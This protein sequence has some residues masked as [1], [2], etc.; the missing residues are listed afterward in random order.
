MFNIVLSILV[1]SH[2]QRELLI[3]CMKSLLSQKIKVPFEIVISDDRS[4]DGTWELICDYATKYS[5]TEKKGDFWTPR[6]VGTQ[7]NSNECNPLNVSERCGWNK[8]NVYTHAVGQYCV[9]I[10]ADDYLKSEDIYQLQID[11]LEKYPECSMCMQE[12]WQIN[13]GDDISTGEIWP[14]NGRLVT[15]SILSPKEFILNGYRALNQCYMMKRDNNTDFKKVY[16]KHFDDT[17]ITQH[18][19]QFGPCVYI[20]R[21]DYVWVKYNTSITETLKGDDN[22]V[23]NALLPLHHVKYIPTFKEIFL[24]DG[25]SQFIHLLKV[26]SDKNYKLNLTDR[27]LLSIKHTEGRIYRLLENLNFFNRM[28]LRFM[29]IYLLLFKKLN[30]K[31]YSLLYKY[32]VG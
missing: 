24:E 19:L 2:N 5:N 6:V 28:R 32:L 21:A 1:I 31:N 15:E 3:R 16:G 22:L 12:V 25:L 26:M 29:R 7:C 8:L 27:T 30:C 10:D 14:V 17:I 9:N 20:N 4:T 13:D 18:H 23:E 11:T